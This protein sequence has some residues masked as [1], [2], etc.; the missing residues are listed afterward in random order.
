MQIIN[1]FFH[2]PV[3]L[4]NWCLTFFPTYIYIYLLRSQQS[5]YYS[6]FFCVLLICVPRDDLSIFLHKFFPR[7]ERNDAHGLLFHATA[8]FFS[9]QF[10]ANSPKQR[11][12][13][14]WAICPFGI[15]F[16]TVFFILSNTKWNESKLVYIKF[17]LRKPK[18]LRHFWINW[19]IGAKRN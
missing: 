12:R 13:S 10:S 3:R 15:V 16:R 1:S 7:S 2:I 17:C 11:N 8:L 5:N 18:R 4:D 9:G 19:I 6:I 14:G